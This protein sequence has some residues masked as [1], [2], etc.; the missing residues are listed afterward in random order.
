[1]VIDDFE[2]LGVWNILVASKNKQ[3]KVASPIHKGF[4][5]EKATR[6]T[7]RKENT[8]ATRPMQHE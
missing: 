3:S 1:M 2:I 8:D 5:K 6:Y 7:T 4:K